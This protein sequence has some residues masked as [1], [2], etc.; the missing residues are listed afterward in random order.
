MNSR[1][2]NICRAL[3][4]TLIPFV[5]FFVVAQLFAGDEWLIT[6]GVAVILVFSLRYGYV[7]GE[8]RVFLLGVALGLF[9]EV[10]LSRVYRLQY[11]TDTSL[12]DVPIWVLLAW[13]GGFVLIRR[14]ADV[15][16]APHHT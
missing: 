11:W 13:G 12:L 2:R 16:M 10:V 3:I 5:L 1:T 7:K 4:G 9:I 15:L 8:W 6:A 14:F